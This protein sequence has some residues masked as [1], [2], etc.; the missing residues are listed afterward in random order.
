MP[1]VTLRPAT[2]WTEKLVSG[3]NVLNRA[4]RD[5]IVRAAHIVHTRSRRTATRP[6]A[7][8]QRRSANV[9]SELQG[10]VRRE[11]VEQIDGAASYAV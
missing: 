4:H 9:L 10:A 1:C 11:A 5:A 2:E 3:W 7:D 6:P 8:A